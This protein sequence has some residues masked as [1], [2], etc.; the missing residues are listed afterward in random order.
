MDKYYALA[1]LKQYVPPK[2]TDTDDKPIKLAYIGSYTDR[3][4][5][6]IQGRGRAAGEATYGIPVSS[7]EVITAEEKAEELKAK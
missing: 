1:G 5:R 2:P 3:P 6:G 7:F 4:T